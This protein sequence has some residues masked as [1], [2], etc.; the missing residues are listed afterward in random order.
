MPWLSKF[1]CRIKSSNYNHKNSHKSTLCETWKASSI[2]LP[3]CWF[4]SLPILVFWLANGTSRELSMISINA[5]ISAAAPWVLSIS[6]LTQPTLPKSSLDPPNGATTPSAKLWVWLVSILSSP[7][8]LLLVQPF[9]IYKLFQKTTC[10]ETE[11]LTSSITLTESAVF[12]WL[13]VWIQLNSTSPWIKN[14]SMVLM[15]TL[16]LPALSFS[17]SLSSVGLMLNDDRNDALL[18]NK[19]RWWIL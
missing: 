18:S 3:S 14:L 8:P 15:V 13:A 5:L 10:S 11:T 17:T 2:F 9:K 7:Y 4:W 12:L 1:Y 6:L 16:A 19:M